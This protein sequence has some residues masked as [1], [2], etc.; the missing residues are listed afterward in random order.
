MVTMQQVADHAKVSISTVSFV[1]NN[2]KPVTPQTRKRILEA[3]EELGYRRNATARALATR[4]SHVIVLVYPLLGHNLNAFVEAAAAAAA[5]QDYHLMLAPVRPE[6]AAAEVTSLIKSGIADGVL[7]ME[8]QL[9]DERVDRMRE[10][11]APFAL[12][13]RTRDT[14]GIDYV[15]ID[16]E[17]A[18]TDAVAYLGG[19]GHRQIALVVE[20]F[21]GTA[22]AGYSPPVRVVETFRDATV[23]QALTGSVFRAA[24][25]P[26]TGL[27]TAERIAEQAPATTAII[28]VHDEAS[29]GLVN[30]L[31]R[32]GVAIPRDLSIVS[33][34]P[35]SALGLLIDPGLT[36]YDA[37]GG[38]LGRRAVEALIA[39]LDGRDG[40]PVQAL[41]A[42]RRHDGASVAPPQA[43]RP[44]L[45]ALGRNA[46]GL[47]GPLHP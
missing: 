38:E 30:G 26:Q 42:C 44:P 46:V 1:V 8:V 6:N 15:D 17:Q 31:R 9:N 20:D 18:T 43:D 14:D 25:G 41:V 5:A 23:E 28:L 32:R 13:G 7:L 40:P 47:P 34:A 4:R 3:I 21:D 11:E 19:L 22:L 37:P 36:T 39:R 29:F 35:S 16:F 12:I 45:D 10:V 24:R 2:T 33:I 27:A